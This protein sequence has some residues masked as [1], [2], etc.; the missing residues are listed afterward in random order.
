MQ[1]VAQ[2]DN[3]RT[4]L[5]CQRFISIDDSNRASAG[6]YCDDRESAFC[7]EIAGKLLNQALQSQ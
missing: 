6:E 3:N 1:Q 5:R 4:C 7:E 2:S